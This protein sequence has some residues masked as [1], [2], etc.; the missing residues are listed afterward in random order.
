ME[1]PALS[2]TASLPGIDVLVDLA[3]LINVEEELA[4]LDKE[5]A[6]LEKLVAGKRG[7]LANENFVRN[8]PAEV[9]EKERAS[10]AELSRTSGVTTAREKLRQAS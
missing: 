2:A 1:P 9:V 4:R 7:K 8:A 3:G 5:K 6:K 10:L